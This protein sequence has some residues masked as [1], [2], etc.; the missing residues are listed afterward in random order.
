MLVGEDVTVTLGVLDGMIDDVY[1][2]TSFGRWLELVEFRGFVT[3][4]IIPLRIDHQEKAAVCED[5]IRHFLDLARSE[6][7]LLFNIERL[8]IENGSEPIAAVDGRSLP[9]HG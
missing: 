4:A 3:E 9:M 6:S 1:W 7:N 2:I 8:I 5:A